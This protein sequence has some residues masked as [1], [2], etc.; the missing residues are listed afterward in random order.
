M[1]DLHL[2]FPENRRYV[3]ETLLNRS[4]FVDERKNGVLVLAGDIVTTQKNNE[5]NAILEE[6]CQQYST[7][8]Y[9]PGNHDYYKGG[10]VTTQAFDIKRQSRREINNRLIQFEGY[11][12]IFTTLWTNPTEYAFNC[13]NDKNFIKDWTVEQ[14]RAINKAS[15]AFIDSACNDFKVNSE[16]LVIVTH[17]LPTFECIGDKWLG[18]KVNTSFA[19]DCSHIIKRHNPKAWIHG[20]SHCFKDMMLENTRIVRNPLGYVHVQEEGD[21]LKNFY[22]N[23]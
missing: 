3:K 8:F 16:K 17:H 7:V 11:S 21:F 14:C 18:N 12:F 9:V 5:A 1:S 10:P 19:V 20:H 4:E 13:L 22:I 15:L 23:V 2:E 6:L